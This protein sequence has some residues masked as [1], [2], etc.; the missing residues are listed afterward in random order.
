MVDEARIDAIERR[1]ARLERLLRVEE[2]APVPAPPA[3]PMHPPAA[4][5]APPSMPARDPVRAPDVNL[6]ELFGGRVLAWLGGAAGVLRA[7]FFLLLARG[8]GRGDQATPR[9]RPVV[10]SPGVPRGPP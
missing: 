4:P 10:G 3:A 9:V 2:P 5:A 1:L 6:E 8:P 7:G